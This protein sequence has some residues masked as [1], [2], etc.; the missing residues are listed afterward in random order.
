MY[1]C[2]WK[3]KKSWIN[4]T[5]HCVSPGYR[6]MKRA[7][8]KMLKIVTECTKVKSNRRPLSNRFFCFYSISV[9][10]S[11]FDDVKVSDDVLH[12]VINSFWYVDYFIVLAIDI[13]DTNCLPQV[14][15]DF[16]PSFYIHH[17]V[18]RVDDGILVFIVSFKF[19][20]TSFMCYYCN[21]W[22]E[23]KHLNCKIKEFYFFYSFSYIYI[24]HKR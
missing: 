11:V 2:I 22:F 15:F 14:D 12:F 10:V 9:S 19:I 23:N 21:S 3:G 7:Q 20:S 4:S 24:T 13:M 17:I 8:S 1:V 18:E 16:L 6:P 5:Q